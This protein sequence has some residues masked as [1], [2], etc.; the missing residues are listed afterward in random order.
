MTLRSVLPALT[1]AVVAC[2]LFAAPPPA[3]ASEDEAAITTRLYPGWNMMGWVGSTTPVAN[4]FADVPSLTR[5]AVWDAQ[6]QQYRQATRTG[7]GQEL[8]Q[9]HTR[10]GVVA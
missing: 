6:A 8:S 1:A 5:I 9:I 3:A 2:L 7:T 4:L 10:T